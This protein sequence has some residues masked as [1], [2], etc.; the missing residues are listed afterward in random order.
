MTPADDR[1]RKPVPANRV[2]DP[3]A[4]RDLHAPTPPCDPTP[5]AGD[6]ED[7]R[8][9][10][11]VQEY[12]AALES[13][14]RPNRKEFLARHAD[15]ADELAACLDGLAFV[16]SAAGQMKG[17]SPGGSGRATDPGLDPETAQPL[18]DF[19]LVREI[20][21]GGMGVVYEA[22]QL[23]LGRRVALKVLPLAAA[24]DTKQ[25]QRFRNEAQAAAQLH[26]TNIVPVYAVGSERGVHYY[27][28]QLIEGQSL[29]DVIR[30]LRDAARRLNEDGGAAA[31]GQK[32]LAGIDSR[33]LD[34]TA[35]WTPAGPGA[36]PNQ[37]GLLDDAAAGG[38]EPA[39]KT[40][41]PASSI[42][43]SL[44]SLVPP[45]ENLTTLRSS[46]KGQ[47]FRTVASLGLQAAEALEYAHRQG[48]V[49][50]DI[51]PGNLLLDPRGNLWI[52]DF[53]LAQFYAD[54]NLTQP[55][56]LLGTLRYMSP[57]QATGRAVVLD[58]RT[59]IYSLGVTFY[60]LLTLEPALPGETHQQLLREIGSY[61]PRSPRSL[62]KTIPP[63]LETILAKSAAKDPA[64][65][66]QSAQA[67]ADDLRRFL[68]DE[69]IL[70]R[71][72]SL[73]DKAVKWTRRHR[74]VA[75]SVLAVLMLTVIGLLTTTVMIAQEQGKTQQAYEREKDSADE[76]REQRDAAER[77]YRRAR[78]AVDFFTRVAAEG[79]AHN[80]QAMEVRREMLQASLAYY[81]GFLE[82]HQNDPR[83]GAELAAAEKQVKDILTEMSAFDEIRRAWG[84]ASLLD[85]RSVREA[86]GLNDEQ[87][88]ERVRELTLAAE[89]FMDL[90]QMTPEQKREHFQRQA[91]ASRAAVD[92][93]LTPQQAQRLRQI[94]L[95]AQGPW[96]FSNPDVIQAL[97]LTREQ[98]EAVK[99]IQAE[100]R[101]A[102]QQLFHKGK[103][104]GG[105]G[106]GP[107]PRGGG[108]GGGPDFGGWRNITEAW[109]RLRKQAV[110]KIVAQLTP[111][112]AEV[113][114]GLIGAPF[115]GELSGFGEPG[116]GG[117]GG[118]RRGGPGGPGGRGD[119]DGDRD[120]GGRDGRGGP[121]D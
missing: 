78:E 35:P 119:R 83:I 19:R 29:S 14:S 43:T 69:P 40:H 38:T 36:P 68:L 107:G 116:R 50:R 73:W 72:P 55:G 49:H 76:A 7:P 87:T 57:E 15:I 11:A 96:A 10:A 37:P 8:L 2:D 13:G 25:L 21:R 65:R 84:V 4:T 53:G 103:G 41:R 1:P 101:E 70:A 17:G 62:D 3:D 102:E 5:T 47:Y 71:P 52:T 113:W 75:A 32:A 48:V 117:P 33:G 105:P 31:G 26:H 86:L 89:P 51:K 106:P 82:E 85:E 95:Q 120:R 12:M 110:V 93:V 77:N 30:D 121:K 74:A 9:F 42:S 79:L 94:A 22:V 91:V 18:G 59:D 97:G 80:M 44:D 39:R 66:Y 88:A 6:D 98:Q 28:M 45:A 90:S 108:G 58:Q 92:Q 60:E 111:A 104:P 27:A 114:D 81:Q 20:G 16:H 24:L 46:K 112:Q 61:D 56:D 23:S 118:P 99:S 54:T 115:T 63:E 109:D 67:L 100:F 64:D 34:A